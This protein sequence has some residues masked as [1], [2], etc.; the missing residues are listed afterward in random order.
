MLNSAKE[1]NTD[2]HLEMLP[3]DFDHFIQ[4]NLEIVENYLMLLKQQSTDNAKLA[5]HESLGVNCDGQILIGCEDNRDKKGN[6]IGFGIKSS[7]RFY[8]Y[9]DE[10]TIKDWACSIL[11]R[12]LRW[13]KS[14]YRHQARA[15][16]SQLELTFTNVAYE[17]TQLFTPKAY[18]DFLVSQLDTLDD[19]YLNNNYL[20]GDDYLAKLILAQYADK[21][22]LK[23]ITMYNYLVEY[24]TSCSSNSF[25]T[26][27]LAR[28]LVNFDTKKLSCSKDNPIPSDTRIEYNWLLSMCHHFNFKTINLPV[29]DIDTIVKSEVHLLGQSINFKANSKEDVFNFINGLLSLAYNDY[30]INNLLKNKQKIFQAIKANELRF[31]LAPFK[32]ILVEARDKF[33]NLTIDHYHFSKFEIVS[34]FLDIIL[35]QIKQEDKI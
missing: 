20:R 19:I 32:S 6:V 28:K 14:Q 27:Y 33:N 2:V 9:Q 26:S 12:Y 22:P 30:I 10:R 23:N 5:F 17:G 16:L 7:H 3:I 15:S 13:M 1:V 31:Q 21:I 29:N 8:V 24:C 25:A 4:N 11:N 34:S 18:A 35:Q